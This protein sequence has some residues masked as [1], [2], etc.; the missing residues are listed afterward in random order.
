MVNGAA[1]A[2]PSWV[3]PPCPGGDA[4]STGGTA[5][6]TTGS[7]TLGGISGTLCGAQNVAA[8]QDDFEDVY[9]IRICD[10]KKFSARPA[11]NF[12]AQVWLFTDDGRGLLGNDDQ[13][14][15]NLEARVFSPAGDGT[16]QAIPAPGI[17]LLAISG[18]NN[19]PLSMGELIF[20]QGSNTEVSGPDGSGGEGVLEGWSGPGEFGEYVIIIEGAALLGDDC[21]APQLGVEPVPTM[22]EWGVLVLSL[23]VLSGGTILLARRGGLGLG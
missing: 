17:Y 3:E 8:G 20:A 9:R 11:A 16:N 5:Q 6:S 13:S 4:G 7:G 1:L 12:N 21:G 19:D 23:S 2:G 18:S 14:E 10:P 15:T 22:S